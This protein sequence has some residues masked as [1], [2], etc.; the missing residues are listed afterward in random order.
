MVYGFYF[1]AQY[2]D[3]FDFMLFYD[4]ALLCTG[5]AVNTYFNSKLKLSTVLGICGVCDF[6]SCAYGLIW[7]SMLNVQFILGPVCGIADNGSFIG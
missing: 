5:S 6:F 1:F 7:L 3:M 2:V 4:V